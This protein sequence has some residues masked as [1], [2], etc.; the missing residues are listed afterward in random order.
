MSK[1]LSYFALFEGLSLHSLPQLLISD[2]KMFLILIYEKTCSL[3]ESSTG[4]WKVQCYHGDLII[5][6]NNYTK[7]CRCIVTNG[8]ILNHRNGFSISSAFSLPLLFP[9]LKHKNAS[10]I[11]CTR[12]KN[13]SFAVRRINNNNEIYISHAAQR[14]IMWY[15]KDKSM[16]MNKKAI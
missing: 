11:I 5:H 16:K 1:K 9:E 4:C 10:V 7:M 2:K 3:Y 12:T 6:R 13:V 14:C 8:A 15:F